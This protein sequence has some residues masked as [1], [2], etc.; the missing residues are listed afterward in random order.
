MSAARQG[1]PGIRWTR[2]GAY[3]S[4]F[5]ERA[6]GL[7]LCLF[8]AGGAEHE[9][10][11]MHRGS[12]DLWTVYLPGCQHGQLYGYRAHGA[13]APERGLRFNPAKLLIDPYARALHGKFRWADAVFDYLPGTNDWQINPCDSAAHVPRSVAI[14]AGKPLG[15][16]RKR[17]TWAELVV[18]EANVRGYTMR[19]PG[20][21]EGERGRFRGLANGQII[22]YLKALGITAIELMPVQS[23]VDE[24]FLVN[25]GLRNAW[26]YNTLNFFA[27]QAR[28]AG[29]DAIKEFRDMVRCLHDAGIEVILDMVFNHTAEGDS[30]GPSLSMRGLDQLSYYRVES[31]NP[32]RCI[33]DTGTGNTINSDHPRVQQMVIE[34]LC[35]W[36]RHM[37]VDG[38]RFD[39]ATVLGRTQHGF[40]P[41]HPLL[42][43]ISSE[44][45]LKGVRL[46]AEPWDPGPG[47]Y[48]LGQFPFGWSEWNDRFRDTVRR[49][50]RG[51]PQQA[52]ELAARMS[53]SQDLFPDRG[54]CASIN[55]VTAHDG[56]T[57]SDLVSYRHRHNEA[58]GEHNRD[59]HAHNFSCN[60]GIE[61][62]TGDERILAS[63]RQHRLNLLAS[64]LLSRGVPMLLA[65]DEFGNS[66]AGNNNAYAQDNETGWLDWSGLDSDPLFTRQ[67]G[68]LIRLR[69]KIEPVT[70]RIAWCTVAGTPLAHHEW[71]EVQSLQLQYLDSNQNIV[72][73]LL[74]NA[75]HEELEFNLPGDEKMQW[76]LAFSS[77][78]QAV[79]DGNHRCNARARTMS[80]LTRRGD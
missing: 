33:N 70:D 26:G 38:F 56:F 31:D 6:E 15:P 41:A 77:D 30:N 64:L 63:R 68:D 71:H 45:S 17:R 44:P 60:H 49:F 35:Y 39:L 78:P 42:R 4:V 72:A 13:Y 2:D 19:H 24:Q 75:S 73:L 1:K 59:G 43:R 12:D 23:F 20:L 10:L 11:H 74:L 18:Y 50:W 32:L 5:S 25:R 29:F 58:N 27:P 52:E 37:G 40:D 3:F 80:C 9:R 8:D 28:Y 76:K 34:A 69:K 22:D 16:S 36:H 47:G 55:F 21:D 79:H 57:L 46:V 14:K 7:E 48:Q 54:P 62:E 65:G 61:G 67:V 66:Q 53:G 51:E